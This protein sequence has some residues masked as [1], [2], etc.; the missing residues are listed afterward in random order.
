LTILFVQPLVITAND[1]EGTPYEKAVNKLTALGILNED[2]GG[3]Y[4]PHNN[5]TR[6][7]FAAVTV[8]LLGLD[9]AAVSD[10][11]GIS[12]IFTDIR[13]DYWGAGYIKTA[14]KMGIVNGAGNKLFD[15]DSPVTV[16]NAVK[17]LT[18]ILG[19]EFYARA[20]G[21]Y[22]VGYI[23]AAQSIGL[24]KGLSLSGETPLNRGNAAIIL[25]N[26]LT[27]DA[28]TPKGY[29]ASEVTYGKKTLLE[30]NFGIKTYSG[31][32]SQNE[33]TSLTSTSFLEK[34]KLQI[35]DQVFSITDTAISK[36]LGYNVEVSYKDD[37]NGF[38]TVVYAEQ[39][40]NNT[41][42]VPAEEI[43]SYDS[44]VLRYGKDVAS[45]S[46]NI[47]ANADY[48]YNGRCVTTLEPQ[49]MTP[50][51]GYLTLISNDGDSVYD[52][53][54][55]TDYRETAVF[56]KNDELKTIIDRI[57]TAKSID[58]LDADIV[59]I[60]DAKGNLLEEDAFFEDL[61][62]N[63]ILTTTASQDGKIVGITKSAAQ[64]AGTVEEYTPDSKNIQITIN[65]KVYTFTRALTKFASDNKITI[66][67][68]I[69]IILFLNARGQVAYFES[70]KTLNYEIGYLVNVGKPKGIDGTVQIKILTKKGVVTV[71]NTAARLTL[72][73]GQKTSP[74]DLITALAPDGVVK[75]M[76]ITYKTNSDNELTEIGTSVQS[77]EDRRDG[78]TLFCVK[79]KSS[80]K[81]KTSQRCFDL[82]VM[83]KDSTVAF[84]V[85]DS[86]Q[87]K[88]EDDSFELRALSAF[89]NDS[90][91]NVEAYSFDG[92]SPYT[93]VL[94]YFETR[95][96]GAEKLKSDAVIA[97]VK[98]IKLALAD[99]EQVTKLTVWQENKEV[100]LTVKDSAVIENIVWLGEAKGSA[101]SF[102]KLHAGDV[103]RY[104][105][106]T[107]DDSVAI[108][109]VIIG[110][111]GEYTGGTVDPSAKI[112]AF[113]AP[114][115]GSRLASNQNYY[116]YGGVY[117][118]DGNAIK[119][120]QKD[121]DVTAFYTT[122]DYLKMEAHNASLYRITVVVCK[123]GQ[124]P[125]VRKGSL[126]DIADFKHFGYSYNTLIVNRSGDARDIVVFRE[127]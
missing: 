125:S 106:S 36:L 38:P 91:Y 113:T 8:R 13:P 118:R 9:D 72:D 107:F 49:M 104:S 119:V 23:L 82:N 43:G 33:Y 86:E 112:P 111:E 45:K 25:Y 63:D 88:Y 7:E 99:G 67:A 103:I 97:V 35:G 66:N 81:W 115:T 73:G 37:G 11:E 95:V 124:T 80:L 78:D 3:D 27:A 47:S 31:I 18:N 77:L 127:E 29:G 76:P 100:I 96:G 17:I 57:D 50:K 85:P 117:N 71:F 110:T 24:L 42:F 93:D 83:M 22:P 30:T 101:K 116:Y 108:A 75:N 15:P 89:T 53:V 4:Y 109:D 44:G 40:G 62:L 20:N 55:I 65:G 69:P 92:E 34:G 19:Y 61:A 2:S 59:D 58:L 122:E 14:Y 90:S 39:K 120:P 28:L 26:A 70:E 32:V 41:L 87:Y 46:A 114:V 6:A 68:G 94:I 79:A 105:K 56:S 126:D 102:A 1:I 60:F 74:A 16:N 52:V 21:G 5:M 123:A 84:L 12:D 64:A 48:I 98:S 54:L 10:A 121:G 51:D